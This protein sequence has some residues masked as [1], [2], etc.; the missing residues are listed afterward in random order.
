M[1]DPDRK[2]APR[3]EP[4]AT[5]GAIAACAA[6]VSQHF[7]AGRAV[8]LACEPSLE[9]VLAATGITYLS[10]AQAGQVRLVSARRLEPQLGEA[11]VHTPPT[12]DESTVAFA[13]RVIEGYSAH[14][15]GGCRRR[16]KSGECPTSCDYACIQRLVLATSSDD[17]TMPEVVHQYLRLSFAVGGRVRTM[18]ADPRVAAFDALAR[19]VSGECEHTRQFVRFSHLSDGSFVGV[20]APKADTIPLVAQHF[21]NRMGTERF[22][23]VDPVHQVAAFHAAGRRTCTVSRLDAQLSHALAE[24]ADLA[25]DE[26]YVRAMWQRFYRGTT[27]PGRDRSQ[28]GYDLR[29]HWMPKHFWHGLTE[30]DEPAS[31]DDYTIPERYQGV[32]ALQA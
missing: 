19:Y 21:A 3:H 5:P 31:R 26:L 20:F 18:I 10:H 7:A 30:L 27:T 6:L 13:R 2:L 16:K 8:A 25:E 9:G 24:R 17:P 12:T 4:P 11:V 15:T 29:V 14:V 22:C 28:R 23:L 32:A 1:Q